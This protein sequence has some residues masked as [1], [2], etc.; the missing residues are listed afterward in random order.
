[1]RVLTMVVFLLWQRI[2]GDPR[3]EE[4]AARL[5]AHL[6]PLLPA[7][8]EMRIASGAG[9]SLV[10]LELPVNGWK[11]S[12]FQQDERLWA[13]APDYPV[14]AESAVAAS[15]IRASGESVLSVLC[16]ALQDDAAPLVRELAP[17]FSLIWFEKASGITRV[18]ND[19]LGQAQLF[20]YRDER[21]WALTN[22]VFALKALDIPLVIEPTEWAVRA[23]LGWFPLQST[24]YRGIRFLEPAVQLTL[25]G[26]RAR[27]TRVDVL[28]DWLHPGRL[29]REDCLEL[30]R[31]SLVRQIEAAKPLWDRPSVGLS[32]GWDSR[33][34]VAVLRS[35]G[36]QFRA[37]VRAKPGR[38]D[39]AIASELARLGGFDIRVVP[40]AVT[41][42]GGAPGYRRSIA[43][44]LRWQ[45]G[46]METTHHR[47]FLTDGKPLRR[48]VNVM[49]QHG[50]IG[51][52]YYAKRVSGRDDD[53]SEE[54]LLARLESRAPPFIHQRLLG[55]VRDTIREAVRQADAYG[56]TGPARL[57]FFYLYER[58]RRWASGSL[59]SQ[60][61]FVFAPFLNPDYIRAVFGYPGADKESYPFHRHIVATHAPAWTRISHER[62]LRR[63]DPN[64]RRAVER[65][66][67]TV[68]EPVVREA[69]D[70]GGTWTQIFSPDLVAARWKTAPD[71]V[72]M[73]H[74]LD[75]TMRAQEWRERERVGPLAAAAEGAPVS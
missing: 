16:R 42:L 39:A 20:E 38:H 44:A 2:P 74:L 75:E 37:R 33:A 1:M 41:P 52:A 61:G 15:G 28:G 57:D 50:E 56:L 34:V 35:L 73:A 29:S 46:Y 4:V 60:T 68:A 6:A 5:R 69:L 24:G 55:D 58:T 36:V 14:G 51:R 47:S 10:S 48:V 45:A 66:W 59:S 11:P 27:R 31:H 7:R 53:Q 19:G 72:A 21:R 13:L 32:G 49:G 26:R 65:A 71:H 43:L 3:P 67:E 22:R 8:P 12:P 23:T 63:R 18:Q 17:P 70:E 25:D 64:D 54:R 30:A 40:E 62:D 9:T